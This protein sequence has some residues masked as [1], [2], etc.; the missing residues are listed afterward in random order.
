MIDSKAAANASIDQS[1]RLPDY[2]SC[3]NC[4]GANGRQVNR[5]NHPLANHGGWIELC[6][7]LRE[8]NNCAKQM[9]DRSLAS[10]SVQ[11]VLHFPAGEVSR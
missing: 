3:H 11:I 9:L 8:E 1:V 5:P 7:I 2:F 6:Q 4:V 10:G